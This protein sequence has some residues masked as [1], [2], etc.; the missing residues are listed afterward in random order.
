MMTQ[1]TKKKKGQMVVEFVVG[2][3]FLIPLLSGLLLYSEWI[4]TK[5]NILS[6]ARLGA[7]LQSTGIV[8]EAAAAEEVE[9]YL[10]SFRFPSESHVT[11]H[12][13]R[14]K[15]SPSS[16][17]YALYGTKITLAARQEWLKAQEHVVAQQA[18]VE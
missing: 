5:K 15:E 16:R 1:R 4:I 12:M 13:G 2:I 11:F 10:T 3:F 18:K 6:A 9:R 14:Y 17:F 7:W 8:A